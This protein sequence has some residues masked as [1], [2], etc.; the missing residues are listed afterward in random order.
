VK[1]I[2]K[3]WGENEIEAALQRL[4]RLTEEEILATASQTLEVVYDLVR[5]RRVVMDGE[6]L[7]RYVLCLLLNVHISRRG[8]K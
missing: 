5:H 4:H 6:K 2:K 8:T 7:D 3:L 1:Y